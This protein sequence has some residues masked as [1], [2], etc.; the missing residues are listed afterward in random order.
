[1]KSFEELYNK[2]Y[3]PKEEKKSKDYT[4]YTKSNSLEEIRDKYTSNYSGN[5]DAYSREKSATS[6]ENYAS[7]YL[8]DL[9]SKNK[10]E[11][12]NPY[13]DG[14]IWTKQ[15]NRD[16]LTDYTEEEKQR[17]EYW[18]TLSQTQRDNVNSLF[19]DTSSD[20]NK[21]FITDE[22]KEK[23]WENA[24]KTPLDS[25]RSQV[26]YYTGKL[27]AEGI[28]IPEPNLDTNVFSKITRIGFGILGMSGFVTNGIAGMINEGAKQ[29][30]RDFD[31]T[32]KA[33]AVS[34][35]VKQIREAEKRG[36]T[37]KVKELEELKKKQEEDWTGSFKSIGEQVK[38]M[39]DV[40]GAGIESAKNTLL[41][42]FSSKAFK[43]QVGISDVIG[44]M[45]NFE[46]NQQAK[47]I[48][49]NKLV[50]NWGTKMALEVAMASGFDIDDI[51]GTLKY[52]N[53]F[54]SIK[55]VDDI[56]GS[57]SSVEEAKMALR[58]I[59]R[60]NVTT[61]VKGSMLGA[62]EEAVSEAI[63]KQ[64]D[65]IAEKGYKTLLSRT[66]KELSGNKASFN[67]LKF[68]QTT[69]LGK[70][71]IEKI[72]SNKISK[73]LAN[74]G[75]TGL[76]PLSSI[77]EFLKV[78]LNKGLI[79]ASGVSQVKKPFYNIAQ[80]FVGG[81]TQSAKKALLNSFERYKANGDNIEE[82][83]TTVASK[84]EIDSV[85][86]S[87]QLQKSKIE[88]IVKDLEKRG[89][90]EGINENM[91]E[92]TT[93]TE[94]DGRPVEREVATDLID[95]D[96]RKAQNKEAIEARNQV[97]ADIE[98]MTTLKNKASLEKQIA[99]GKVD[100]S[101]LDELKKYIDE[102]IQPFI[103]NRESQIKRYTTRIKNIN[104]PKDSPIS[105]VSS[106]NIPDGIREMFEDD[107]YTNALD[108]MD[109]LEKSGKKFNNFQEVMDAV[110]KELE[111]TGQHVPEANLDVYAKLLDND[112][113]QEVFDLA[114]KQPKIIQ[115]TETIAKRISTLQTKLEQ[116]K[117]IIEGLTNKDLSN[118]PREILDKISGIRD[119][120]NVSKDLA[121]EE[122]KRVATNIIKSLQGKDKEAW[123]RIV[124]IFP[125][126]ASDDINISRVR[127]LLE[128]RKSY[129]GVD[130][131]TNKFKDV[132]EAEDFFKNEGS[133]YKWKGEVKTRVPF[134]E[135][136]EKF[137]EATGKLNY[138]KY[139]N[140]PEFIEK[141]MDNLAIKDNIIKQAIDGAKDA[142]T[143]IAYSK[144]IDDMVEVYNKTIS[145]LDGNVKKYETAISSLRSKFEDINNMVNYYTNSPSG[146]FKGYDEK[147]LNLQNSL[148]SSVENY[149]A[150]ANDSE[151]V[152]EI[153]KTIKDSFKKMGIEEGI[154]EEVGDFYAYV[155]HMLNPEYEGTSIAKMLGRDYFADYGFGELFNVNAM[156]RRL[157]GSISHIN[158][159]IENEYGVK[160]YFETNIFRILAKR[161]MNN[162]TFMHKQILE[163][164]LGANRFE[165]DVMNGV[166][167]LVE[168]EELAKKLG[169]ELE[170]DELRRGI[171][172]EK[173][174]IDPTEKFDQ[175]PYYETEEGLRVKRQAKPYDEKTLQAEWKSYTG[176][177]QDRVDDLIMSGAEEEIAKRIAK[178][179]GLTDW[180]WLP[181]SKK[182]LV[183][184]SPQDK[185]NQLNKQI[186]SKIQSISKDKDSEFSLLKDE[187]LEEPDF[188]VVV[189]KDKIKKVPEGLVKEN[190]EVQQQIIA[191]MS[192]GLSAEGKS[193]DE[194]IEITSS[195][196]F[197]NEVREKL[198]KINKEYDLVG[199]AKND[200][201]K[202]VDDTYVKETTNTVGHKYLLVDRNLYNQYEEMINQ[203]NGD[204]ANQVANV[205]KKAQNTFKAWAVTSPGFHVTNIAGGLM[206][207]FIQTGV[208][209]LNPKTFNEARK[210]ISELDKVYYDVS[211]L[212]GELYGVPKKDIAQ[213]IIDGGLLSTFMSI[214]GVGLE[215]FIKGTKASANQSSNPL[216]KMLSAVNPLDTK[217]NALIKTSGFVGNKTEQWM[218]I[219]NFLAHVKNGQ[220]LGIS[221]DLAV[222]AMF[223][224][225]DTTTFTDN[226]LK[227]MFPFITF[228]E[229][230]LPYFMEQASSNMTTLRMFAKG[231][232]INNEQASEKERALTPEY[233]KD[234]IRIGEGKYLNIETPI[235][236]FVSAFDA[237]TYLGQLTPFLKA[238]I[239]ATANIKLYNGQEISPD[240]DIREKL[241]YTMQTLM[242]FMSTYQR[243]GALSV[244]ENT[245]NPLGKMMK[246]QYTKKD[247]LKWLS[248]NKYQTFDMDK[249]E[250]QTMYEYLELLERVYRER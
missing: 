29:N 248:G 198:R 133:I 74:V 183:Q 66:N 103:K 85:R 100:V 22:Y 12:V 236:S 233:M 218:K 159:T 151:G 72:G 116:N 165:Y 164:I 148:H 171:G 17:H 191:E 179:E 71:T 44:T 70:E 187:P 11:I 112:Y 42:P 77:N 140:Q 237:N 48:A 108:I 110:K 28:E 16:Y 59:N 210:I 185:L 225:T 216:K 68:G 99:E 242:P 213:Q 50:D 169:I 127:E 221:S 192:S 212:T 94:A 60:D 73:A 36:D 90:D 25:V 98:D 58:K 211:K 155:F 247:A 204:T 223:D 31:Q 45:K 167:N 96:L 105:I 63:E 13:D 174:F 214:E 231:H 62:T 170:F 235:M 186:K 55:K 30:D 93:K 175:Y 89:A 240:N 47:D 49:S 173:R 201:F 166:D 156:D 227:Q 137:K 208:D 5:S 188:D 57:A 145:D 104:T 40:L 102:K 14:S 149:D 92:F 150:F 118:L 239:E 197:L 20:P 84:Y 206:N 19:K 21:F 163:N 117:A 131:L 34:E 64:L 75:L 217:N 224:Y 232:E 230:N 229:K 109:N 121:L 39:G 160:N 154:V 86:H 246:G 107:G 115:D 157:K 9:Y 38:D 32:E 81:K 189:K 249:A 41:S 162:E 97:K 181:E 67:G 193:V 200:T 196:K 54:D 37:A 80:G 228:M 79:E 168:A 23:Y 128:R 122:N 184:Y 51:G 88:Q 190:E 8:N 56:V 250:S 123:D 143:L 7:N 152:R 26:D 134:S 195:G 202:L 219:T 52:L 199:F 176:K 78:R 241:K 2:Y 15:S 87:R 139:K 129:D 27:N 111:I 194:I 91:D 177:L 243:L 172:E 46:N 106:K 10:N 245:E 126:V 65:E 215:D 244:D 136:L 205:Y 135:K 180:E 138:A 132:F 95:D 4:E 125:D 124:K 53:N 119:I 76:N 209:A 142:E 35:T 24:M 207:N 6:K 226:T 153:A 101:K 234:G 178:S 113:A 146:E 220:E 43:E 238:P 158:K 82:I 61:N 114:S 120:R 3:K 1:M 18:A 83:Y 222:E 203:I 144:Q 33:I 182:D 147:F 141:M 130:G 69:I 161:S